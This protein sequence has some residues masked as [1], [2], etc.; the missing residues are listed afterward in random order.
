MADHIS[1][2][3]FLVDGLFPGICFHRAA[4]V[5][6]SVYTFGYSPRS[7]IAGAGCRGSLNFGR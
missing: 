5:Q 7:G 6:V 3:H 2:N 1:F 4:L